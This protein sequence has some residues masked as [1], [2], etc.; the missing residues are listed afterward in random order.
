MF[1]QKPSDV[2]MRIPNSES[3]SEPILNRLKKLA[4]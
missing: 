3:N 1:L 2:G 4:V